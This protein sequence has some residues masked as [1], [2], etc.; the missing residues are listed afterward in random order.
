MEGADLV[1]SLLVCE[2]CQKRITDSER[3]TLDYLLSGV[4]SVY[5]ETCVPEEILVMKQ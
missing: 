4:P 5:C 3:V 1:R 2:N